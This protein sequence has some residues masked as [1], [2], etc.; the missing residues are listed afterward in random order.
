MPADESALAAA[1]RP[2]AGRGGGGAGGGGG[3]KGRGGGGRGGRGGVVLDPRMR[4]RRIRVRRDAGK[5][6][7]R[8]LTLVLAVLALVV[9]AAVAARSP[10]LNVDRVEVTGADQTSVGAVLEAAAV[11]PGEPLVLVDVDAAARR[12]EELPW[13]DDAT[14]ARR[15]PSTV[16]V[17]VSEREPAALAQVTGAHIALVD[18]EGRVLAIERWP[19]DGRTGPAGGPG[20]GGAEA[21]G[22]GAPAEGAPAGPARLAV[23]TDVDGPVVE[24]G[25]LDHD[26][27]EA[28]RVAVA[29][30]ERMP[31]AVASV[32]T[33]F[34][35]ELA[36][37]GIIRFGDA[38]RLDAKVTAAKTVLDQV[39]LSCLAVLDVRV[40]GSPALTR[41]QGC[42]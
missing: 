42:S 4:A 10:L 37:G 31:G 35:A 13:V 6:R 41:H 30:A 12:V 21:G 3:G 22:E 33:D 26:A 19:D 16:E 39:D 15:W 8:R 9:G 11:E 20:D 23:L 40:P 1:P 29:V 38:E 28:L 14:V 25:T 34:E 27:G 5:R 7:L 18:A 17:Q 2:A 36:D 32:S 24:G